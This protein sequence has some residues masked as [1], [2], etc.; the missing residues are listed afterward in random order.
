MSS[1]DILVRLPVTAP[2]SDDGFR[3]TDIV[4]QRQIELLC[5]ELFEPHY[6]EHS[7]PAYI[8]HLHSAAEI[9]DYVL[10]RRALGNDR[11]VPA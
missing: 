11:A 1:Y 7:A 9:A 4:F 10:A 2:L 3:S 6:D 8:R 5:D